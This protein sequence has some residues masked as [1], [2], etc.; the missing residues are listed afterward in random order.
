MQMFDCVVMEGVIPRSTGSWKVEDC[1][2]SKGFVCKRSVGE[3]NA[4]L[5]A[6]AN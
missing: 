2:E 5:V 4:S 3:C 1:Y 6:T